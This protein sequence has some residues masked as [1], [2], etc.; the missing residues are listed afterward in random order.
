[1]VKHMRYKGK[2]LKKPNIAF[3]VRAKGQCYLEWVEDVHKNSFLSQKWKW[4]QLVDAAG[5]VI[6]TNQQYY[7][8][9]RGE[10][11]QLRWAGQSEAQLEEAEMRART[12]HAIQQ[13]ALTLMQADGHD[14]DTTDTE[15]ANPVVDPLNES[16][17]SQGQR[18]ILI[19]KIR[20]L[21]RKIEMDLNSGD[22]NEPKTDTLE[23]PSVVRSDLKDWLLNPS[24]FP[25]I[26]ERGL[27]T[28]MNIFEEM[29]VRPDDDLDKTQDLANDSYASLSTSPSQTL[30]PKRATRQKKRKIYISKTITEDEFVQL[31][32]VDREFLLPF[33]IQELV[34]LD[35][36]LR[37]FGDK[38][39]AIFCDVVKGV[40]NSDGWF[41]FPAGRRPRHQLIGDTIDKY[42]GEL[43]DC[44]MVQYNSLQ[45][46]HLLARGDGGS[47]DEDCI[48]GH[49][50]PEMDHETFIEKLK[51]CSVSS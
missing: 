29:E 7:E 5:T 38:L 1:M 45:N 19:E 20:D 43:D 33:E 13:E 36:A 15:L 16:S 30:S 6:Q 47:P 37:H 2:T 44:V 21:F 41:L 26:D 8:N 32:R 48:A 9:R 34:P 27:V 40:V 39:L 25:Q 23:S 12:E 14:V 50:Q 28:R 17:E 24:N 35:E 51:D 46:P 10:L 3:N 11:M 4:T 49:G 42:G 22:Q 31:C 18:A